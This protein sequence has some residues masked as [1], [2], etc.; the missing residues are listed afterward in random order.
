LRWCCRRHWLA[1]HPLADVKL[2]K[3]VLEPRGGPSLEQ[4]N[5]ILSAARGHLKLVFAMLAFTGI[6]SGEC[7]RLR[8]ED[9]DLSGN[10]I[11]IQSRLG[12][13]TKTRRSRR[14]PIHPRLRALLEAVPRTHRQWFF[15]AGRSTRYPDGGH[16]IN[17]KKLNEG[18]LKLAARLGMPTGRDAGGFTI[19][20]LRHFFET[21]CNNSGIPQRAIDTWL[22]HGSDQSMA[23]KYYKLR[24]D[25]SQAFM[26]KVPFW[27][28]KPAAKAG[29][30]EA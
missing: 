26:A 27:D 22:G 12:G 7:Q 24:D 15:T 8:P 23:A 1:A 10:W 19:H 16:C 11:S 3:P 25:E 29:K 9:V 14:I 30:K 21:F 4:V 2:R 17:P 13:E 20:S 28:G 6:R 5:S 18:F